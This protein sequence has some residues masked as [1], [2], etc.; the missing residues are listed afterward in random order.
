MLLDIYQQYYL[1]LGTDLKPCL[2]SLILA[3]LP[4]FEEENDIYERV[5]EI[6]ESLCNKV[7]DF[8]FYHCLWIGII[9]SPRS[10]LTAFLY[11]L[12][13]LGNSFQKE[14]VGFLIGH[15]P[16]LLVRALSLS[17]CDSSVLVQRNALDFL[18]KYFPLS[19][20]VDIFKDKLNILVFSALKTVL[21]KDMSLNRRLYSWLLGI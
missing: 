7:G 2:K 16:V 11:L 21:S 3:L 20:S 17:L 5:F 4:G 10:R 12:K 18:L 8:F 1:P 15:E 13:K 9:S 14:D 6:L 19:D